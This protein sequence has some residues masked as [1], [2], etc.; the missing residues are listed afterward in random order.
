MKPFFLL[1]IL[2][3]L[4]CS[5]QYKTLEI[6]QKNTYFL[7]YVLMFHTPVVFFKVLLF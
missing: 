1:E 4:Q 2:G 5:D 7:V 6:K 3:Y